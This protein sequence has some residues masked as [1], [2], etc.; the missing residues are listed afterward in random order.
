MSTT[1]GVTRCE[2]DDIWLHK[3][4]NN[5]LC[6]DPSPRTPG[7]TRS[8]VRRRIPHNA[9]K[10]RQLALCSEIKLPQS[11]T[12]GGSNPFRGWLPSGIEPFLNC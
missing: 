2:S 10:K 7:V 1:P 3:L 12:G 11:L 4:I 5:P 9:S 8:E 6:G